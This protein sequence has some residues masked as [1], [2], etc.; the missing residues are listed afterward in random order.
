[1]FESLSRKIPLLSL[2][3]LSLSVLFLSSRAQDS[4]K[5]GKPS[6]QL[7]T[8]Y[9][10]IS[11]SPGQTITYSV[12]VINNTNA[13]QTTSLS[14][15][16]LARGW[17]HTLKSGTWDVSRISVLPKKQQ[18]LT[19]QVMVPLKVNKGLYRVYVRSSSGASLPLSI[20]VKEQ[21]TYKTA[22]STTQSNLEGAANTTFTFNAKLENQTADTAL[23][24][25]NSQ[26]PPG[27]QVTF[28]ANYKQVASVSI[29]PNQTTSITIE[30]KAPDE[31]P[32]GKYKIPVIAST[33]RSTA[34]LE[35]EVVITGSYSMD[36]T[37]PTGI[38]STKVSAG[39]E[40]KLQLVVKNSGSAP[41]KK[42]TMSAST[43]ANWNV[44]FDPKTIDQ[45]A[46]GQSVEVGA[47]LKADKDAIAGDYATNLEAKTSETSAKAQIR[48]SV[49]TPMIWGWI[50]ILIILIAVGSVYYLFRKYGRR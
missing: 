7:Y 25:L 30:V 5:A 8:P 50:G 27:W 33:P 41:L 22:F 43:P 9:S 44:T 42:I 21:G 3:S 48:V 37:T 49:T 14:V 15:T 35:L 38:L 4:V 26:A 28:K 32:A 23:Y 36:L 47:T 19:L 10:R 16:G 34:G 18:D 17:N 12:S 20:L 45:L 39:S 24:A 1:M 31:I 46:P 6:L 29:N 11:V 2:L 13:I 40:K